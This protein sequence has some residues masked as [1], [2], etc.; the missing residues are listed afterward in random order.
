MMYPPY[1]NTK[2][3][4]NY[5]DLPPQNHIYFKCMQG[6]RERGICSCFQRLVQGIKISRTFGVK[7]VCAGYFT[8]AEQQHKVLQAFLC[9]LKDN[10]E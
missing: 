6:L 2:N 4:L 5:G 9:F 3:P 1:I 7:T 10:Q 8:A